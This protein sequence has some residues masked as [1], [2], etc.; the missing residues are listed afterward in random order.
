MTDL[1]SEADR[2]FAVIKPG[3][4][5]SAEDLRGLGQA[6]THWKTEFPQARHIGGLSD[7]LEGHF[8]RTPCEYI[9]GVPFLAG[10]VDEPIALAY[11]TA[12]AD[13]AQAWER[14]AEALGGLSSCL[15]FLCDPQT[16]SYR[17]R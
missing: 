17:N 16:Y 7:L 15:C 5:T 8:P 1:V 14:M 9:V 12:D 11:V 6:L 3:A 10:Q 13:L 4:D 2:Q